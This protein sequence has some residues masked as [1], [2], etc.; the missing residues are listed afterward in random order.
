MA[1]DEIY[2]KRNG[3]MV[4]LWGAVDREEKALG[5]YVSRRGARLRRSSL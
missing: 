3:E 5:S 1:P 2:M 4:Y